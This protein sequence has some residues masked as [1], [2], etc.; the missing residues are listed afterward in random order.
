MYIS[1]AEET[2][3]VLAGDWDSELAEKI[4]NAWF[5]S[6][7]MEHKLP[8]HIR[9]MDGM[10]G[11]KYRYLIN[12]LVGS[13]EDARYLEIGSW[14]GS[15]ASA[16]IYG[17]TCRAYCIDNWSEFLH[18]SNKDAVM[19]EFEQNVRNAAGNTANFD[20]VDQDFRTVDYNSLGK[21]NVYMFDGPH[22]EQDQYDGVVI[23]QPAVDDEYILIVDDWNGPGVRSGTRRALEDLKQTIV[24]SIE[25]IT[26]HDNQHPVIHTQSSDWHNGYFIAVIK[27]G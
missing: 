5:G 1:P 12:N 10:S 3:I 11:K 25:I 23:A 8:D 14:K 27:K 21:F 26:R 6:L 7:A 18:G 4:S 20:F 15:T 17:N 16:A 2:Q 13:L 19:G 9:Y 22:S 24:C